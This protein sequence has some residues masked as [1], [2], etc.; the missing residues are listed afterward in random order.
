MILNKY[1]KGQ[2][3]LPKDDIHLF[4]ILVGKLPLIWLQT[5]NPKNTL[6]GISTF[7]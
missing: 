1:E 2:S 7:E 6:I 5:K 3:N 4:Y